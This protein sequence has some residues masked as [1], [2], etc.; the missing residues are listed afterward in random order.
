VGEL[1]SARIHLKSEHDKKQMVRMML[2]TKL[3]DDAMNK[4]CC[5]RNVG[6]VEG[7]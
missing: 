6:A 7:M 1:K 3:I 5:G 4:R 2:L